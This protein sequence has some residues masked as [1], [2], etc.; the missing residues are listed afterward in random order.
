M[1]SR[2]QAMLVVPGNG[3]IVVCAVN[4]TETYFIF[5][6]F[7]NL[8]Q[9]LKIEHESRLLTFDVQVCWI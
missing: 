2:H 8:C 4:T 9:K 1:F 6:S 3:S 7:Q 5:V